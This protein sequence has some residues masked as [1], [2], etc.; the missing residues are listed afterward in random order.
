V[1]GCAAG[2]DVALRLADLTRAALADDGPLARRLT[3]YTPRAAQMRLAEAIADAFEQR[4]YLIA[5]AGTG[6]GKTY[7]Y[8]VPALLSGQRVII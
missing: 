7:A 5:E 1:H 4:D 6:T 2:A 8:L 3:G